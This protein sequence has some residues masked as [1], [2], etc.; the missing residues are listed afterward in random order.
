M[1][2]FLALFTCAENSPNHKAWKNLEAP[3]QKE[4][5]EAGMKARAE[6]NQKYQTRVLEDASLHQRASLVDKDGLHEGPSGMGAF[7][8]LKAESLQE[9]TQM[10]R[11][12]PHFAFFPGDGVKIIEILDEV[13]APTQHPKP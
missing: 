12:H 7:L 10:F 11:Q 1:P 13:K 9:A 4:R 6:W 5:F 2:H 3:R 8:V